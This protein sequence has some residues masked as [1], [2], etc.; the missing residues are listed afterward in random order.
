[1]PSMSFTKWKFARTC[2][3]KPKLYDFSRSQGQVRKSLQQGLG[4]RLL[5]SAL[6]RL[7][8]SFALESPAKSRAEFEQG[9]LVQRLGIDQDAIHIEQDIFNS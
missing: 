2:L 3:L 6:E 1:M 5:C 4:R 9:E 8:V 7:Q